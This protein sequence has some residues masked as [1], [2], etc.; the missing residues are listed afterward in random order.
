MVV[1]TFS[2]K[3]IQSGIL[4]MY[5]A[6]GFFA[7]LIFFV[8]NSHL[9]T[10]MQMLF[11]TIIATIAFKGISNVMLSLVIL[12]F[13]L[14]HKYSED[15]YKIAE[16]KLDLLANQLKMKEARTKSDEVVKQ[17]K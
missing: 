17:Q 11:W 3:V 10:P 5:V 1:E 16:D 9:F 14:K 13:N 4:R 7:T 15:H 2:Q 6:S 8:I 12:L